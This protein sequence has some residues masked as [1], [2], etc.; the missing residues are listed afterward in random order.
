MVDVTDSE[1]GVTLN[2]EIGGRLWLSWQGIQSIR[3][4]RKTFMVILDA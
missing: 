4:R 3:V 2:M 1:P